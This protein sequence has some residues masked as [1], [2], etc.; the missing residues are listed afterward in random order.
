MA[1]GEIY[2]NLKNLNI[3]YS[4]SKIR[5]K[6]TKYLTTLG[7]N[8]RGETEGQVNEVIKLYSESKIPQLQ[9]AENII[10]DLLFNKNKKYVSKKCVKLIEKHKAN[11]PLNKR[12]TQSTIKPFIID[13]MLYK[14]FSRDED[15]DDEQFKQRKR[16]AKLYKK[17]YEQIGILS[18]NVKG[19]EQ[20]FTQALYKLL[21]INKEVGLDDTSDL[22]H[23]MERI[24]KTNTEVAYKYW[25]DSVGIAA[26]YLFQL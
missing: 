17:A 13:V 9:T 21:E 26:I 16:R 4:M 10:V 1:E 22:F 12:L 15:E 6:N 25:G 11:E 3:D 2:N 20:I 7:R 19:K 5:I 23:K 24:L 8:A 14:F 18:L